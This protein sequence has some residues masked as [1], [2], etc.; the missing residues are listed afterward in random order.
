M[1][2]FINQDGGWDLHLRINIGLQWKQNYFF[3]KQLSYTDSRL[4]KL[5]DHITLEFNH[6]LKSHYTF[7][8]G[9]HS[10]NGTLSKLESY[11]YLWFSI[12][13]NDLSSYI[14]LPNKIKYAIDWPASDLSRFSQEGILSNYRSKIIIDIPASSELNDRKLHQ[15]DFV[16]I[17][18]GK[19]PE[20]IPNIIPSVLDSSDQPNEQKYSGNFF[21]V[22]SGH[23]LLVRCVERIGSLAEDMILTCPEVEL[24]KCIMI[25]FARCARSPLICGVRRS[26]V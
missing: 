25:K 18:A 6:S 20:Q 1:A 14:P 8:D 2:I 15:I 7:T 3:P 24:G 17:G 9:N 19:S 5:V 4:S 23:R 22:N 26:T 12:L 21:D 11:G 16:I 10:S 13:I